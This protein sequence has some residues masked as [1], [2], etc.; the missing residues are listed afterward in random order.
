KIENL[1]RRVYSSGYTQRPDVSLM[2]I[3]SAFEMACWDIVGKECN[4]PVSELLGGAIHSRLRSYSYIYEKADDQGDVFTDPDIAAQRA[5][6]FVEMG[7]SAIKIDPVGPYT[8]FDPR[9]ISLETL[10]RCA[11]YVKQIREAIGDKADILFGTHGQLT[12]SSAIRLAK[13]LEPYDPLWFEEPIP[14]DNPDNM[15]MVAKKT[16]IPVATGERLTTKY[17][18]G[19]VLESKAANILQMALGRVGGLLEAKKIAAM[20]EYYHA[21]IAPH[22]YCGPIEGAANIHLSATCAN[23]LILESIQKWDGFHAKILKKPIIWEDGYVIVPTQPGLGV[24]LDEKVAL[25]HPYH[26][27]ALHLEMKNQPS[28]Q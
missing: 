24:E 13:R 15:A 19:R 4:Q 12:P 11:L 6:E 8:A 25:A 16:T 18:F 7:F 3:L 10:S 14:P 1:F 26:D 17:E 22:L 28:Y 23:F 5:F 27:Q 20:A 21:Q 2:G 9:Q